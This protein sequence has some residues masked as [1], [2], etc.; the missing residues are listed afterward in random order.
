[1]RHHLM[2]FTSTVA[3]LLL[4]AGIWFYIFQA[5]PNPEVEESGSQE[6]L[7]TEETVQEKM[8]R[9]ESASESG[10][11]PI[12]AKPAASTM[13]PAA[14]IVWYTARRVSSMTDT[15]VSSV[16][17]GAEVTKVSET[18]ILFNGKRFT[19]KPGDLTTDELVVSGILAK[20]DAAALTV[21]QARQ[22]KSVAE[23]AN[24]AAVQSYEKEK[25]AA[26]R[27]QVAAAIV[28]IDRQIAALRT[29]IQEARNADALAA[30]RGRSSSR[31]A[32]ISK[33]EQEIAKLEAERL[34]L[35]SMQ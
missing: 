35:S 27:A 28:S 33:C 1:M 13:D 14:P 4:V 25:K 23:Q 29:K 10:T 32:V 34:R 21:Q 12:E 8:P 11:A 20:Q 5:R 17:A 22:N 6:E 3:A 15:G 26:N 31:G 19:V 18:E 16:P 2:N 7:V 30:I 24:I 9:D